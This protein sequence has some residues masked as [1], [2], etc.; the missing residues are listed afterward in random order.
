VRLLPAAGP[1]A[2]GVRGLCK[3][4]CDSTCQKARW[5]HHKVAC[6][7]KRMARES[8][9]KG[10]EA[11]KERGSGSGLR[12]MGSIMAALMKPPQPPPQ[13]MLYQGGHMINAT[14]QNHYEELQKIVRQ[15]RL[16]VDWA[17]PNN[18]AI[19]AHAAAEFGNDKCLSLLISHGANMSKLDKIGWAP[20][21]IAC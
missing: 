5:P 16:D 4:Y 8:E 21:H 6:K 9:E 11:V 14:I 12:D 1:L 13:P 18:R 19:A 2:E 10:K 7:A 3:K 17:Q 15:P 20:I